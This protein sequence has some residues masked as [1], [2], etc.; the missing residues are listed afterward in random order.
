VS[1][2][3]FRSST[4]ISW[5]QESAGPVRAE[6]FDLK[7][8]L[9]RRLEQSPQEA[10]P[11]EITWDGTDGSGR[12]VAAGAYFLQVDAAGRKRTVRVVVAR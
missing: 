8:R 2:N 5:N 11:H 7:G 6:I 1:P 4:R 3:P 10:G 9:V 12:R